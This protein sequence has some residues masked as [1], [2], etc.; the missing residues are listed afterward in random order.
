MEKVLSWIVENYE[1]LIL[2]GACIFDIVLFL[3]GVFRKKRNISLEEI[4]LRIPHLVFLAE[5][6]FG[7]GHG[8][9]KKKMVLEMLLDMYKQDTGV[10]VLPGSDVSKTFSIYLSKDS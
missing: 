5:E 6:R 3:I 4:L 10:L 1:L 2:V 8:E 7:Q 9:L